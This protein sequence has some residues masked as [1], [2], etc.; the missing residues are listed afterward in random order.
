M[1][2]KHHP[3]CF[4]PDF[5]DASTV[6]KIPGIY[7]PHQMRATQRLCSYVE[8]LPP[9]HLDLQ[10]IPIET[11]QLSKCQS[12]NT[13]QLQSRKIFRKSPKKT[14]CPYHILFRSFRNISLKNPSSENVPM[15]SPRRLTLTSPDDSPESVP[16]HAARPRA[17]GPGFP[18]WRAAAGGS[19]ARRS[20]GR[21]P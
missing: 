7:A 16:P 11:S 20:P 18:K 17:A 12:R 13:L 21:R 2:K 15:V 10:E 9:C 3:W 1:G 4:F 8:T 6:P 19:S 5:V 14:T